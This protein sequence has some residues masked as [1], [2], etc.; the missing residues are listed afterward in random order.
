[1][2]DRAGRIADVDGGFS[3]GRFPR[4]ITV[5]AM[6]F[7]AF[8]I[9]ALTA[10]SANHVSTEYSAGGMA[11]GVLWW[12]FY[13]VRALMPARSDPSGCPRPTMTIL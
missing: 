10:P 1:M 5:A 2:G 3:L 4:P 9:L 7:A 13:P 6:I 11:I 8:A 12:L